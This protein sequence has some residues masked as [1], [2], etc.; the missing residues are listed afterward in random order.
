[1]AEVNTKMIYDEEEDILSL[2]K[3]RKV[4]ASID[5][6]DFIIDVDAD[7]FISGLEILNASSNLGLQEVQLKDLKQA[8]MN[9]SYKP[10][11]VH[12]VLIMQ[13]GSKEKDIHIP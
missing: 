11:Y 9:I 10:K 8:S 12:I 1:M 6:G 7:G 5:L 3:N 4:K 2:S 13:F